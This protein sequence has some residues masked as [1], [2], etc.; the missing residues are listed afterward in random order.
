MHFLFILLTL[1]L[2]FLPFPYPRAFGMELRRDSILVIIPLLYVPD[3]GV[4][5]I[6]IISLIYPTQIVYNPAIAILIQQAE[7]KTAA[8]IGIADFDV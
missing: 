8:R 4:V 1:P 2:Q 3:P 5:E 7:Y 6:C